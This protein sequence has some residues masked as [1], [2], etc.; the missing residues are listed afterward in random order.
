[1]ASQRAIERAARRHAMKPADVDALADKLFRAK[2]RVYRRTLLE[3]ARSLGLAITRPRLSEDVERSLRADATKRARQIARTHNRDLA[4]AMD[5]LSEGR[6]DADLDAAIKTWRISR[7]RKRA[8]GTAANELYPA[9]ADA[10][11][12][13]ATELGLADDALWDFGGHPSDQTPVCEI[14]NTLAA[15]SPWTTAEVIE[16]GNPHPECRQDWHLRSPAAPDVPDDP[17]LGQQLAGIIG[18]EPYVMRAGSRGE[19]VE[20]L[21]ALRNG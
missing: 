1:V 4:R 11:I 10:L 15:L 14:C 12:S 21:V 6:A 13:A 19:A 2:R 20:Q 3:F 7:Q 16:I 8:R 9:H 5:E 18:R 17:V